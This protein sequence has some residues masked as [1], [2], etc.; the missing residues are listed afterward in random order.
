MLALA[1]RRGARVSIPESMFVHV[2]FLRVVGLC[3]CG[4]RSIYFSPQSQRGRVLVDTFGRTADG[5]QIEILVW[6][7]GARVT[8]VCRLFQ[9]G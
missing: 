4:C 2:P 5:K 7:I 1:L 3:S 6:G 8:G 9:R